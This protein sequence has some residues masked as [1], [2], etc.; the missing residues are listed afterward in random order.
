MA[1]F[2]TPA[3]AGITKLSQLE[4]DADKD[5]VAKKIQ[6]L[7]APDSD[8]DAKRHDSIPATHDAAQHTDVTREIFISSYDSSALAGTPCS[9]GIQGD[10]NADEPYCDFWF[11]VPDDFVSFMKIEAVW[12]GD[13]AAGNMY[14]HFGSAYQASDEAYM[15][16][17]DFPGIGATATG[18]AT[19]LNVQEPAN[20]L[21]LVN[22]A[23]GDYLQLTFSREG[24]NALD[25]LDD[26]MYFQGILFTYVAT[27]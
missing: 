15:T 10:A 23:I 25:T 19:I 7:G 13:A 9:F 16:H 18:G 8:D 14:W 27:Q 12:V 21:T 24:T 1:G 2:S 22:L 3:A 20:P 4:I 6:N 5:W 11:K 17:G 26:V